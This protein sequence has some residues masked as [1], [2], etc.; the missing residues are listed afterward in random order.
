MYPVGMETLVKEDGR[1]E[2]GIAVLLSK[3]RYWDSST[4]IS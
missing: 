4:S 2:A 3:S 1:D